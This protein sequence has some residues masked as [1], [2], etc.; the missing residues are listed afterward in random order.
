MSSG[1]IHVEKME[2]KFVC[3]VGKEKL[4]K[5]RSVEV[6][7]TQSMDTVRNRV[8]ACAEKDGKVLCVTNAW[9]IRVVDTVPVINHGSAF[10]IS[11]GEEYCAIK[12]NESLK[13][14]K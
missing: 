5:Y 10:A 6:V 1:I 12:V 4:A 14:N 9:F 13:L 8:L 3:Q 11:T 2:R 7:V